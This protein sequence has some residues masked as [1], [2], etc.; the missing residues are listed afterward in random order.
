MPPSCKPAHMAHVA[1]AHFEMSAYLQVII[2][3]FPDPVVAE[4]T[5]AFLLPLVTRLTNDTAPACRWG[6][7]REG[8]REG[9]RDHSV[10]MQAFT[11]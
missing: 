7:F 10:R 3:K 1:A 8:W 4:W 5:E 2:A 6:P 9:G 11:E